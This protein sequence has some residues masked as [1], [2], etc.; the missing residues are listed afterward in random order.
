[1]VRKM[2]KLI[3]ILNNEELWMAPMDFIPPILFSLMSCIKHFTFMVSML[4]H[5]SNQSVKFSMSCS[6]LDL[7]LEGYQAW[8]KL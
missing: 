2:I 6:T 3:T 5:G 1:M 8:N 7:I 4:L